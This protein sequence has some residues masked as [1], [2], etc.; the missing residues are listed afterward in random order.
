M[1]HPMFQ[2][3]NYL[4]ICLQHQLA[5]NIYFNNNFSNEIDPLVVDTFKKNNI[6]KKRHT[7]TIFIAMM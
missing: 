2:N 1:Y 4:Y 5:E 7:L 6:R 3:I